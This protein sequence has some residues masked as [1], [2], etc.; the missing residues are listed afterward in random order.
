MQFSEENFVPGYLNMPE[1]D[2]IVM[3]KARIIL[4]KLKQHTQVLLEEMSSLGDAV[5][6]LSSKNYGKISRWNGC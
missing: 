5:K 2:V 6:L 3:E 1:E 4:N